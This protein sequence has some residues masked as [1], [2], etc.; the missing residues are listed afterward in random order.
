MDGWMNGWV[1]GVCVGGRHSLV[2]LVWSFLLV[3]PQYLVGHQ[4]GACS[5]TSSYP[6]TVLGLDMSLGQRVLYQSYSQV[7]ETFV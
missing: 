5:D 2:R 3:L 1:D 6:Y 4:T 7:H